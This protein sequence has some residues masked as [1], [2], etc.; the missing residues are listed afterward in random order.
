[1]IV[2]VIYQSSA[3]F[4]SCYAALGN[5]FTAD[6]QRP[7]SS[8]PCWLHEK[9]RTKLHHFGSCLGHQQYFN[10]LHDYVALCIL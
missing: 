3:K 9:H 6:Y 2:R 7:S 8:Y 4:T 1:M 10:A 5:Q